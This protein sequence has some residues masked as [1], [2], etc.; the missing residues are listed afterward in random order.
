MERVDKI[1][2]VKES[3]CCYSF[4]M[5]HKVPILTAKKK[6]RKKRQPSFTLPKNGPRVRFGYPEHRRGPV[7]GTWTAL[8]YH[9]RHLGVNYSRL[10]KL[11]NRISSELDMLE[12]H[13][14]A[15]EQRVSLANH[16]L[17]ASS[18]LLL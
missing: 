9:N 7:L 12:M 13:S 3:S 1:G 11:N 10:M 6:C 8:H 15:R 5:C 18:T 17:T 14:W 16:Q 2:S 4:H